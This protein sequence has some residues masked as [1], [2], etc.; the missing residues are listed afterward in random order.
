MWGNLADLRTRTTLGLV[1]SPIPALTGV[2][3]PVRGGWLETEETVDVDAFWAALAASLISAG[4]ALCG[5]ALS[6]R[7]QTIRH[8]ET[9][10]E[11]ALA[12]QRKLVAEAL[13]AGREW[14]EIQFVIVPMM[15][16][17]SEADLVEFVE[18]DTARRLTELSR[19]L[20]VALTQ[21]RLFLAD[22]ELRGAIAVL[23]EFL[24]T[25]PDKVNGPIRREPDK[26]EHVFA[27]IRELS[28]FRNSLGYLEALAVERLAPPIWHSS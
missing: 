13:I 23:Q 1:R 27:G 21:A 14:T 5:V 16:R 24:A 17:M 19:A 3:S 7:H 12:G 4:A 6:N 20:Q 22:A 9:L 18:T 15:S 28:K 26:V 11:E 25:F 10:R 2:D 8:R